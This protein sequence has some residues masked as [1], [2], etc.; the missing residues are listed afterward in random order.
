[1]RN[2]DSLLNVHEAKP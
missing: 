2:V 1:M